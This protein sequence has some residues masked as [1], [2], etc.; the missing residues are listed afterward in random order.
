MSFDAIPKDLRGLRACL[1]CSLVKS[2]DQ[3]E[4]DGCENCEE[5]LRMKALTTPTDSWV[6]KWQRLARFT[7][8][9]YAISVSGT[10][11]QSTLRDMK[12]RGIV[13]KS[14]DRSQR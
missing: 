7:R 13:Y 4:T 10:L 8:G 3:F 11:P 1:V 9:I 6:A 12:N 5:F 14:R 2:F